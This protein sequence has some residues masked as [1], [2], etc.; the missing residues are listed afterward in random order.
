MKLTLRAKLALLVATLAA[1]FA[2]IAASGVAATDATADRL[3]VIQQQLLPKVELRPRLQGEFEH[4]SRALQDAV[5][6]QDERALEATS[7]D[8]DRVLA[9]L[10]SAEEA[11]DPRQARELR[12]SVENYYGVARAISQRMIAGEMGEELVEQIAEMQALQG[13]VRSGIEAATA[14][15]ENE[16]A[17][18]F[19]GV[20][21]AQQSTTRV[22]VSTSVLCLLFATLIYFWVSRALLRSV[23]DLVA[24]F[25]R[26]GRGEFEQPIATHGDDELAVAAR[27]ANT[28]AKNL[29]T[30]G[31][32]RDKAE[33][34]KAGLSGVA[35]RLRGE[36]E[37]EEV[38]TRAVRFLA[39]YLDAPVASFYVVEGETLR[40]VAT[41]AHPKGTALGAPEAISLGEGLL[42]QAALEEMPTV[43]RDLP[44]GYLRIGSS[45][46]E[47]APKAVIAL[48]LRS[49]DRPA[50]VIELAVFK[51][52]TAERTQFLQSVAETITISM[53]V[54]RARAALRESLVATEESRRLA[55]EKA[56]ELATV[57]VYKSQFLANMSHELRTPLNSMLLLSNLLAE[58]QSGNLSGKQVEYCKTIHAAGTDLLGLI[59]QVLDLAKIESGKQDVYA[60]PVE[61]DAILGQAR[62][63]FEPLAAQKGLG[64]RIE[65]GE[66]LPSSLVTDRQRITQVLNNLIGNAIKFTER[67]EVSVRVYRPDATPARADLRDRPRIAFDVKDSGIGVRPEHRARIFEPFE[68]ADPSTG[69][70]HGGTGLGLAIVREIATLLGGEIALES[71][72]GVG[73]TFTL[74]IPEEGPSGLSNAAPLRTPT[75][76]PAPPA[77]APVPRAQHGEN[78]DDKAC[79][80]VVEDDPNFARTLAELV[81]GQGLQCV[82]ASTGEAALRL[83]K[84][85]RPS[86]IVLDLGLPDI[87]GWTVIERLHADPDTAGM[88]VHVVSAAEAPSGQ[89]KIAGVVGY[90]TKPCTRD[91]LIAMIRALVPTVDTSPRVLIVED[92]VTTGD[93]LIALLD[94]ERITHVRRVE[95]AEAALVALAQ[96]RFHCMVLD[97]SLPGMDGLELLR[98]LHRRDDI[99]KPAVVVYTARALDRGETQVLQS[100][101]EAVLQ[102]DGTSAER[103]LEEIRAFARQLADRNE[104]AADVPPSARDEARLDDRTIL[105]V[106][107]DMR[108]VYALS[109]MLRSR[110]AEVLVA[111]NGRAALDVLEG[112]DV[113]GVL[114]DI[115][116]P[117]M[118]GYTAIRR[119]RED[120]RFAALPIIALTAKAM[121]G[122]EE[123]CIEAGAS[124]YLPKPVDPSRLLEKLGS[125][126]AVAR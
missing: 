56:T 67:G 86:G 71:T 12:E 70:K 48:P 63:V 53:Q 25:D 54:A 38:A 79:L 78:A 64:F 121:K 77:R 16:L 93:S 18:A 17:D 65:R 105:V 20:E 29:E 50:G 69:R 1:G 2:I 114:M 41:Y 122:D 115:M 27:S 51:T 92:D 66:G 39:K 24:G 81:R 97:L 124:A 22:L 95:S 89:R 98:V 120:Q 109:A 15:R 9:S 111:D 112:R 101:A 35:E 106:D 23:A 31:R 58:N 117:E 4:L 46:G 33:W 110:G 26:F 104:P 119:I 3:A 94:R 57:S 60:E 73:S 123:K 40:R 84:E 99:A 126:M 88:P 102:K 118:D 72:P 19:A 5:A 100:Y 21:E 90:L 68:Q 36:L 107:D 83:A 13:E 37:L 87:D 44:A 8:R 80:L 28:M 85:Y 10:A 62:R 30:L 103:L 34:F 47:T 76:R 32:E 61:L 82:I 43:I 125:Y 49:L 14:L 42:G 96:Q 74:V 52:W 11:V 91:Q 45:L 108:T 7:A 75:P 6:A 113:D 59:N 55:E 116:M